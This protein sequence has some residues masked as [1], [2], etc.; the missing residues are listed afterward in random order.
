[1]KETGIEARDHTLPD[2]LV[3]SA[4]DTYFR[5]NSWSFLPFVLI[6]PFWPPCSVETTKAEEEPSSSVSSVCRSLYQ[7]RTLRM[8]SLDSSFEANFLISSHTLRNGERKTFFKYQLARVSCC[9]VNRYSLAH[10]CTDQTSF[11]GLHVK[12]GIVIKEFDIRASNLSRKNVP[13]TK[14]LLQ[15]SFVE[16]PIS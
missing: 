4:Y 2:L 14:I 16:E 5:T 11:R 12:S 3:R 9:Q 1:M 10:F 7:Y 6:M 13:L 8:L 15:A